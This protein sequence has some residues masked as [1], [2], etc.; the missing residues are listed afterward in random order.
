MAARSWHEPVRTPSGRAFPERTGT[1]TYLP[2]SSCSECHPHSEHELL[3]TY[4][5][6]TAGGSRRPPSTDV[7]AVHR[8]V[9]QPCAA[10]TTRDPVAVGFDLGGALRRIRRRADLSQRELAAACGVAQS[11]VAQAESGRRGLAVDAL[12]RAAEV[13]G[14][15]LALVDAE[16]AEVAP[17]TA[18][19]VRD[20]GNRRFPAHVDTRY[21]DE[22][23]WHDAHHYSRPRPWYTFDRDR[24]ARDQGRRRRGTPEDHLLPGPGDSPGDRASARRREYWQ[25]R[26]AERERAFLAGELSGIDLTFDCSCPAACDELDDRSGQP[27][28]APGCSCGCDLA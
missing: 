23:W 17:M 13:A 24:R 14:L 5:R 6:P 19:A 21:S 2:A 1:R 26:A 25:Q 8:C 27:V 20:Q 12:V 16:G 22:G 18:D 11:V 10:P 7:G 9:E 3:Q 28:H 4:L 15:R